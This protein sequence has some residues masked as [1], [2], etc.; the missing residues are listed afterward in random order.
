MRFSAIVMFD[1]F[2]AHPR[3]LVCPH[4][5][6]TRERARACARAHGFDNLPEPFHSLPPSLRGRWIS[7]APLTADD[8]RRDCPVS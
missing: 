3:G 7:L 4:S 8:L 5:H 6:R 2:A 1:L